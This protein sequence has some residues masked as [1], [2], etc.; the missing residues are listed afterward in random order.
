MAS[1]LARE[2][3]RIEAA[4]AD[5]KA[6][7]DYAAVDA[8]LRPLVEAAANGD[9]EALDLLLRAIDRLRLAV[10]QIRKVLVDEGDVED[11]VQTTL[12]QVARNVDGFEGRSRFT[13]W[14]YTIAE[15][16]A[17]QLLRKKKRVV[18][19]EG[20]DLANLAEEVRRLSS[21]VASQEAI[22]TAL[23]EIDVK[24]REPVVMRDIEQLEYAAIAEALDIPINTVKTRIRRGRLM[25]AEKILGHSLPEAGLRED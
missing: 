11:A 17:L 3:P 6:A 4:A 5:G 8:A 21:V 19:P 1:D 22:R 13:T 23:D 12:L 24:F 20:Q 25:V 14:L 7:G 2:Y 15:R 18:E 9:A 10:P 16:E